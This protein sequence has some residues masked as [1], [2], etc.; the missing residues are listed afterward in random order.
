MENLKMFIKRNSPTISTVLGCVGVIGTAIIA[1]KD[2]IKATKIIEKEKKNLK[3]E[4]EDVNLSKLD[5]VKLTASSYI[6]TLLVGTSTIACII[7]SNIFNK[8]IQTSLTNIITLMDYSYMEYKDK[9]RELYGEESNKKIIEEIGKDHYE[10]IKD[11]NE[12]KKEDNFSLFW[13]FYS[14]DFFQSTI[15]DVINAIHIIQENY[16][17]YGYATLNDFYRLLKLNYKSSDLL[18]WSKGAGKIYDYDNVLI[19][20]EECKKDDGTIFYTII[21][22]NEPTIDFMYY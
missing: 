11:L 15:D 17:K 2:T 6:P 4:N 21:F 12:N 8:K 19:G 7:C 16:D 18:G 3:N 10:E 5:I 13:D 9:V 14:M 22:N 20:L 1:A